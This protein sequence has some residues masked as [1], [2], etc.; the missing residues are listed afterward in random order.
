MHI[1]LFRASAKYS[2]VRYVCRPPNSVYS[3]QKRVFMSTNAACE[4]RFDQP[5]AQLIGYIASI[6]VCGSKQALRPM[7][8]HLCK[9]TPMQDH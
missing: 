7:R 5:N 6:K 9:C 8:H 4:D 1:L 3:R 2:D